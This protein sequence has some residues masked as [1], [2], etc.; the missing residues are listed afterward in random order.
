MYYVNLASARFPRKKFQS[1]ELKLGKARDSRGTNLDTTSW[2]PRGA[3]FDDT[4]SWKLTRFFWVPT[5]PSLSKSQA[6]SFF[7][8]VCEKQKPEHHRIEM[9]DLFL[10]LELRQPPPPLFKFMNRHGTTVDTTKSTGAR[11][12]SSLSPP[13]ESR[14]P[15]SHFALF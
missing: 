14:L 8:F 2:K 6:I 13:P 7:K 4:R 9:R 11:R 10:S 5:V 12:C 15:T 3:N 1:Q